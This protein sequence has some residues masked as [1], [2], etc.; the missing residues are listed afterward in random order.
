MATSRLA[1]GTES[2][3]PPVYQLYSR[4][5]GGKTHSLLMLAATAN[6]PQLD[7]WNQHADATS[8]AAKIVAFDGIMTN[9]IN[10]IRMDDDDNRAYSLAGYILYQLGGPEALRNFKEGDYNLSDPG[11]QAFQDL[12]GDE[13]T[14][15]IIDELVQ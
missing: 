9:A 11:A 14:L 7:Y 6:H 8:V 4:Y 3:S 2:H 13:P 1:F 12:I 5:G 10:G 15:I